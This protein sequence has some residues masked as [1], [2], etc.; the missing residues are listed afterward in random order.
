MVNMLTIAPSEHSIGN[1]HAITQ[2]LTVGDMIDIAKKL[3][4]MFVAQFNG[5]KIVRDSSATGGYKAT[6]DGLTT[7]C[8]KEKNKW[9]D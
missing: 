8:R 3:N 5:L 6:R 4:I 9:A 7:A 2:K 1:M